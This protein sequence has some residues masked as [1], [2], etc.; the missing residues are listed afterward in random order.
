[1][2]QP[3]REQE[4]EKKENNKAK[5]AEFI[6]QINL[7]INASYVWVTGTGLALDP[8]LNTLRDLLI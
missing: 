1:M 5:R 4:F 7:G 8:I 6:Q 2:K 3:Q